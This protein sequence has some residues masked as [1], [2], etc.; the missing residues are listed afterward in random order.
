MSSCCCAKEWACKAL[1]VRIAVVTGN[2]REGVAAT[3]TFSWMEKDWPEIWIWHHWSK[4]GAGNKAQ[5]FSLISKETVS[6]EHDVLIW[7]TN[8]ALCISIE[9]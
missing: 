4:D 8:M 1:K 2:V 7:F 5:H 6:K 3:K 9:L